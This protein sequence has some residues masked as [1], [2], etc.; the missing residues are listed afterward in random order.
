MVKNSSSRKKRPY[1]EKKNGLNAIAEVRPK[2]KPRRYLLFSALLVACLMSCFALLSL[3]N[4]WKIL[5]L[6]ASY[7]R[8]AES[9][10][11]KLAE[12]ISL[13]WAAQEPLSADPWMRA[14]EAATQRGDLQTAVSYLLH[15]PNSAPV[16][17]FHE[18]GRVQ[19][20][21]LN[22]PEAA[23]ETSLRTVQAYPADIESHQRLMTYFAITCQRPK[24]IDEAHRAIGVGSESL[25]TY[26]YLIGANWLT[27][28][29]GCEVN[30]K[31]LEHSPENETFAVAAV[32]HQMAAR[33]PPE[34][35]LKGEGGLTDV[36]IVRYEQK[37]RDLLRRYPQNAEL[38]ASYGNVLCQLGLVEE[39]AQLL[40]NI[41][42]TMGRESRFWRF[43]GWY[44]MA[45]DDWR[46]AQIA[47]ERAIELWPFD[48][49]CDH[50]LA[51]VLRHTQSIGEANQ[52][53]SRAIL[54]KEVMRL[55]LS[56]PVLDISN[57]ETFEKIHEYMVLCGR[58]EIA[59][60]L[61][62]RLETRP[63]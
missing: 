52:Y 37:L 21:F 32:I 27:M 60:A 63:Q 29:T 24:L 39:L 62:R 50:E 8:A 17:A 9:R 23:A 6:R 7:G 34:L 58:T 49:I 1:S 51:I 46:Q 4:T 11:W 18:L 2:L 53:Q 20:E 28:A 42:P 15:L 61:K 36:P 35:D 57:R 44:H 40:A 5:S 54:G 55:V 47:Y 59:A 33:V 13:H 31:W 19:L 43:K 16:E 30:R 25:A 22:K 38:I 12:D 14:A 41:P 56:A 48:W 3:V 26:A 10:N 45:V